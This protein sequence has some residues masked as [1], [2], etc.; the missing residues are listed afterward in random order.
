MTLASREHGFESRVLGTIE[1][2]HWSDLV[3]NEEIRRRVD[4]P[5]IVAPSFKALSAGSVTFCN[6][7]MKTS[8]IV[9]NK[10]NRCKCLRS[11]ET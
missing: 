8:I 2:V 4:Q 9:G 3:L 11:N 6:D 10:D 1:G 5:N 7:L